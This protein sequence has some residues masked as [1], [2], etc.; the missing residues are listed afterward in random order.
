[1]KDAPRVRGYAIIRIAG[2]A[3]ETTCSRGAVCA[4]RETH[5]TETG[6]YAGR[7]EGHECAKKE[8]I[9]AS[10][11][12]RTRRFAENLLQ[13]VH[14]NGTYPTPRDF[15]EAADGAAAESVVGQRRGYAFQAGQG[16]TLLSKDGT[17]LVMSLT[18]TR[19]MNLG[20]GWNRHTDLAELFREGGRV[21]QT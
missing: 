17:K 20:T 9:F 21:M 3:R 6:D 8:I 14:Q 13:E 4:E 2:I 12:A 19:Q 10:P 15:T 1:L 18:S 16:I 11:P 5:E 7:D